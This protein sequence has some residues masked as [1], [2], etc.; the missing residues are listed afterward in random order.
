M[1]QRRQICLL[2]AT[3]HRE[4]DYALGATENV[5]Q[6]PRKGTSVEEHTVTRNKSIRIKVMLSGRQFSFIEL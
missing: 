3:E 6:S 5:P 1:K 2:G 4:Y